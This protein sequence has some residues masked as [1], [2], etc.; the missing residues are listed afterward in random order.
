MEILEVLDGVRPTPGPRS[1][2]AR[3]YS[4]QLSL[5]PCVM[6]SDAS[7][8]LTAQGDRAGVAA[9]ALSDNFGLD[10]VLLRMNGGVLCVVLLE[11]EQA[12]CNGRPRGE[13]AQV[14]IRPMRQSHGNG[15]VLNLAAVCTST[16]SENYTGMDVQCDVNRRTY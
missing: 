9:P 4:A 16:P 10:A 15:R 8:S 7:S 14:R 1:T 5:A 12:S 6:R 13:N 2:L 11:V 3:R